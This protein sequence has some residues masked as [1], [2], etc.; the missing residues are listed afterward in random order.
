[1]QF[2]VCYVLKEFCRKINRVF[3][4]WSM[5]SS[6]YLCVHELNVIWTAWRGRKKTDKKHEC[7]WSWSWSA[8]IKKNKRERR[9]FLK[10][11]K[12]KKEFYVK[13][14]HISREWKRQTA[15]KDIKIKLNLKTCGKMKI[16]AHSAKDEWKT[17]RNTS[18]VFWL[19]C[20]A[21]QR[22]KL[23]IEKCFFT[24]NCIIFA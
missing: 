20:L 15:R 6:K 14:K 16:Y 3:H 8:K 19:D 13:I 4:V 1:M 24:I 9:N 23:N 17:E 2:F 21:F 11:A 7:A 12:R 22:K 5:I 18:L 10:N